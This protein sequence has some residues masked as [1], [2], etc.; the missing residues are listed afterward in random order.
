[1][2]IVIKTGHENWYNM[3]EKVSFMPDTPPKNFE[4]FKEFWLASLEEEGIQDA[5]CTCANIDCVSLVPSDVIGAKV[6]TTSKT[7]IHGIFIAPLCRECA[8]AENTEWMSLEKN[9]PL[10]ELI[11]D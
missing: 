1:M 6:I 5:P 3:T 11:Y 9:T 10:A 8:K 4:T 2:N 7:L